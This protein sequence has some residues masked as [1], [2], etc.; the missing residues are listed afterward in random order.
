MSK[1]S[2]NARLSRWATSAL[3]LACLVTAQAGAERVAS[4]PDWSSRGV[5]VFGAIVFDFRYELEVL[6]PLAHPLKNCSDTR[7]YC[8]Q[9]EIV[10]IS[11]PRDCADA[12]QIRVGRAWQVG[13]VR[14]EVLSSYKVP[15]HPREF[16]S[17]GRGIKFMLGSAA[18]PYV[19]YEYEPEL[20]VTL[21]FYD[22]AQKAN[23]VSM[24]QRG[25]LRRVMEQS[26]MN[27]EHF[28]FDR[29]TL[30]AFGACSAI[31]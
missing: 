21:I 20:G 11:L 16:H 2:V 9:A 12:A 22:I 14:T 29:L 23:L 26:G 1:P 28:E 5:F 24:A 13:T 6:G 31:P 10:S 7:H 8:A 27:V 3:V 25:D 15:D 17:K 18:R 30:D 19:V 4:R